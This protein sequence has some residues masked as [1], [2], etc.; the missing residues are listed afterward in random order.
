MISKSIYNCD[1]FK[2]HKITSESLR[3]GIL[4]ATVGGFLD[5]YTYICRGNVFANAQTGNIVLVGVYLAEFNFR[6]VIMAFL[7]ILAFIAGAFISEAIKSYSSKRSL[8]KESDY[9]ILIIEIIVL[10]LIGFVPKTLS[11]N[12]V[13]IIISFV[14]SVQICSFRK[15]V[16]SPYSTTMCTGN[17]RT[18]CVTAYNA[19]IRK[20]KNEYV[21]LIRYVFIILS[22]V[23]GACFCGFLTFLFNE[24][25]I[26][27]CSI[28]LTFALSLFFLD[29]NSNK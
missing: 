6:K 19:F 24:K 13:T 14:S 12:F 15:L 4:L 10:F 9:I 23:I 2:I 28:L 18:A 22:F 29:N 5:A 7:P 26:W 16:D 25:S 3:L 17:L 20:E 8:I 27:F 1:L 11:N 21:K